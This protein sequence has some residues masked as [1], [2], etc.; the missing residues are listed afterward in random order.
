MVRFIFLAHPSTCSSSP[1]SRGLRWR[2][3]L[4][5]VMSLSPWGLLLLECS[6]VHV[7]VSV[8]CGDVDLLVV[9][10]VGEY[11]LVQV[12]TSMYVF[13][14]TWVRECEFSLWRWWSVVVVGSDPLQGGSQGASSYL[15]PGRSE[16]LCHC[17]L[18]THR[19][20]KFS[21]SDH[22]QNFARPSLCTSTSPGTNQPLQCWIQIFAL[23]DSH[24]PRTDWPP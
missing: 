11:K 19:N 17:F 3:V 15:V 24:S 4:G 12:S 2:S 14:S 21:F 5:T 9:I 7:Q 13:L 20:Y 23:C 18:L 6:T 8:P 10:Y 22:V 1:H 16:Q